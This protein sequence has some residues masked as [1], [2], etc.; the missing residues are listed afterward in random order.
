[1]KTPLEP[2]GRASADG[3]TN[4]A[5]WS[6]FDVLEPLRRSDEVYTWECFTAWEA[7]ARADLAA[8]LEVYALTLESWDTRLSDVGGDPARED[9]SQF[10]PLGLV[11]EENWSDWLAWLIQRSATGGFARRL[12]APELAP[13]R[14]DFA[15]PSVA[16][17][18]W[19]PDRKFRADILV[20]WSS[21]GR[22]CVEVK[23]GDLNLRKT[24]ATADGAGATHS[25]LILPASDLPEWERA[26][27]EGGTRTVTRTWQE[28]AIILRSALWHD[29]EHKRWRSWAAGF[30]GSVEQKLLRMPPVSAAGVVDHEPLSVAHMRREHLRV[31]SEGAT[32][33]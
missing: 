32:G 8:A 15:H 3:G 5:S 30:V 6:V 2:S 23:I 10:R 33:E 20:D 13:A 25:A 27:G 7:T 12:L 18:V 17:E 14:T 22:T 26:I 1:M 16:R 28:V 19:T 11:R 31:L 9:W 21:S 4:V 29:A 24:D